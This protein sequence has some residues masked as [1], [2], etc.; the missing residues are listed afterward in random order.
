MTRRVLSFP[1]D[2]I[3][4][5]RTAH[6]GGASQA[7]VAAILGISSPTAKKKIAEWGWPEV[8]S[9]YERRYIRVPKAGSAGP[10]TSGPQGPGTPDR[11]SAANVEGEDVP[12]DVRSVIGAGAPAG[13]GMTAEAAPPSM[14][15]REIGDKLRA[16]L[17]RE[18]TKVE[19]GNGPPLL[20][21]RTLASLAQTFR[22]LTKI[23]APAG[24]AEEDE[25][26][27]ADAFRLDLAARLEAL[28]AR[29]EDEVR[30]NA[31]GQ[32]PPDPGAWTQAGNGEGA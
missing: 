9:L 5:A 19:S 15:D 18:M 2:L 23:P 25:E 21:A 8:K 26:F 13:T 29:A 24:K 14:D 6:M 30:M 32:A 4:Q 3:E 28:A 22:V 12:L 1:S 7:E 10:A 16:L 27:D 31:A 20:A 11:P 17:I